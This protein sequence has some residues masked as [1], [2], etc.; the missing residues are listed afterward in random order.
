[1]TTELLKRDLVRSQFPSLQGDFVFLENAGGSQVPGCVIEAMRTF[2]TDSY[3]QTGAGYPASDRASQAVVD[4]HA[5]M[6][7]WVNAARFGKTVLGPSTTALVNLIAGA[8]AQTLGPGDEVIIAETNHEANAGPW[9][10]LAR[11][12]ATIKWWRIDPETLECSLD[13]LSD[14]LTT[15]TRLVAFPHVSNLLGEIVDVAAITRLCHDRGARV[16]V[17]GVAYAPHGVIDVQAWNVDWYVFSNY[18]VYGPHVATLFGSFD[19]FAE[20]QGPNH[21]FIPDQEVPRKW[22]L[23][24]LNYEGCAGVIALGDYI[25]ALTGRPVSRES[26]VHALDQMAALEA[27]LT[28]RLLTFLAGRPGVRVYGPGAR[29]NTVGTISFTTDKAP[30]SA[31]PPLLAAR[32]IGIRHGYMYSYRLC[33]ALGLDLSEGVVRISH[34]HYNTEAEMERT[35]AALDE[36]L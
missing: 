9:E 21:F 16:F 27:P 30:S 22:E 20:L 23:G 17:D 34:V 18:K 31:I 4:A 25:S 7:L 3:V 10:R 35:I 33:Q 1:M 14:L 28:Q 26:I 24:A 2:M 15:R 6:D 8:Y 12:G 11:T 13:A 29:G 19:A 32:G 36:I 5:L